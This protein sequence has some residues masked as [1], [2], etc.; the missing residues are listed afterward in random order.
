MSELKK[1]AELPFCD[2]VMKGGITSGVVYPKL[3][4][5]LSG[6]YRFKN[7][8]GTSAGAI[9]AA[10]CAAAEFRRHSGSHQGFDDLAK[11]PGELSD[12]V[13]NPPASRLRHL[14]QPS[15]ALHKHFDVLLAALNQPSPTARV[16]STLVALL[17][18]YW[19]WALLAGAATFLVLVTLVRSSGAIPWW[20]AAGFS[21][22]CLLVWLAAGWFGVL[23]RGRGTG[24]APTL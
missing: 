3:I 13:G 23:Q 21:F 10:G 1:S 19:A 11:L 7:I 22:V 12:S 16:V 5:R 4:A 8:G 9:A 24:T 2:L 14:F 20:Q 18:Q 17:R 15:V 6:E